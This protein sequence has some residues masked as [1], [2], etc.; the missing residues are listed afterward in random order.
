M[1]EKEMMDSLTESVGVGTKTVGISAFIFNILFSYAMSV[2]WGMMNALQ[3]IG[4]MGYFK[5]YWPV[6]AYTF[7]EMIKEIAEFDLID[8]DII[9][10]K[11][12]PFLDISEVKQTSNT[13]IPLEG[14]LLEDQSSLEQVEI[15]DELTDEAIINKK[16]GKILLILLASIVSIP[17][18]AL[19]NCLK[20]RSKYLR[21]LWSSIRD[22]VFWNG[23]IRYLAE[24]YLQVGLLIF[25]WIF[26]HKDWSSS[27]GVFINL[28]NLSQL[29][30]Y[31]TM[32]FILLIFFRKNFSSF[33]KKAFKRKYKE[34]IDDLSFRNPSSP[35]FLL[36]FSLRRLLLAF[37]I[38]KAAK[39]PFL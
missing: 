4:F 26:Q 12:F 14:R 8:I 33:R 23:P 3:I 37:L 16:I 39:L 30:V 11:T 27:V 1:S 17:L 18:L 13:T 36:I 31:F 24:S 25:T 5:V 19:M 2:L 38:V 28:F 34:A 9:I 22:F 32:P 10:E 6:N 7:Y 29:I 21:A 35:I 20:H 15:E